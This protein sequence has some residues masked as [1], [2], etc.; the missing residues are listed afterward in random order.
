MIH[1]YDTYIGYDTHMIRWY[2]N[3]ENNKTRHD[4]WYMHIEKYTIS[5]KNIQNIWLFLCESKLKSN[6]LNIFN[7]KIYKLL[8][9]KNIIGLYII[10]FI[11][12]YW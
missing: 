6:V 5:F 8:H 9:H 11:D 1:R 3:F 4:T 12:K 7:I 10:Y 2:A